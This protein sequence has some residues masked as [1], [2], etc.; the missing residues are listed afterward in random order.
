[1][2]PSGINVLF[3]HE[4]MT[5]KSLII[6]NWLHIKIWPYYKTPNVCDEKCVHEY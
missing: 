2:D 3:I 1:M 4:Q 6:C 5:N